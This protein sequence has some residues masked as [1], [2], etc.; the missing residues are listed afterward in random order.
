MRNP[1]APHVVRVMSAVARLINVS[2]DLVMHGSRDRNAALVRHVTAYAL[3]RALSRS[4][5]EIARE[6]GYADHT[7]AMHAC[8]KIAGLIGESSSHGYPR[9]VRELVTVALRA[10]GA[11]A[12]RVLAA[13][14]P[15]DWWTEQCERA[16]ARRVG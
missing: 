4:Y 15:S 1:H 6:V 11:P 16:E 12:A 10:A 8:K 2:L 14:Q 7:T 3:R 13:T 9:H 5:P